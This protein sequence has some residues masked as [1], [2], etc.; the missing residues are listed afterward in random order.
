MFQI[1]TANGS[2]NSSLATLG[3]IAIVGGVM[4]HYWG[5]ERRFR[6]DAVG[7]IGTRRVRGVQELACK[8]FIDERRQNNEGHAERRHSP[9]GL[10]VEPPNSQ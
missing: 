2:P 7:P 10:C 8:T 6:K 3:V 4:T 1:G 9:S 5:A